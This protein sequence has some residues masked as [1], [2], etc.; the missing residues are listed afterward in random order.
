MKTMGKP[1][2]PYT[3]TELID[4]LKSRQ[5]GLSQIAFAKEIGISFQMLSD[6]Y[7]GKRNVGNDQV[8]AYLAP[9]GKEFVHRDCWFLVAKS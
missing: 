2:T 4:L 9:K 1:E 7:L 8:L 5:G 3:S 6:I